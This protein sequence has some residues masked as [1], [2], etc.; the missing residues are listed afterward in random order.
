[1]NTKRRADLGPDRRLTYEEAVEEAGK[2]DGP[3]FF[4]CSFHGRG[5]DTKQEQSSFQGP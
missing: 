4:G 5:R 2:F 3:K 1:M